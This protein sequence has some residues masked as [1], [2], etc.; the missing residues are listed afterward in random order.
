MV[1]LP[2]RNNDRMFIF[3]EGNP[4]NILVAIKVLE[5]DQANERIKFNLFY[6]GKI[7]YFDEEV[8]S[9]DINVGLPLK[10]NIGVVWARRANMLSI[11][12]AADERYGILCEY[13]FRKYH[14]DVIN[15]TRISG[16]NGIDPFAL[17]NINVSPYD[18]NSSRNIRSLRY[19][20]DLDLVS[21]V[22][23]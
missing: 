4:R 10:C 14:S 5:V 12:V 23:V 8:N 20:P 3:P 2:A 7:K 21:R 13:N 18:I 19:G 22:F 15:F 16:F 11:M 9:S 1:L 17:R 6:D